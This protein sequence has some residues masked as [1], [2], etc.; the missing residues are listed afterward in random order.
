MMYQYFEDCECD[1]AYDNHR[2][3]VVGKRACLGKLTTT[4]TTT[5]TG[6]NGN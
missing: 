6:K 2:S 4:T 5:T 1:S 3:E